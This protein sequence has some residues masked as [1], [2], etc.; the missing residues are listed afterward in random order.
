M[1]WYNE[2]W[3]K[4]VKVTIDHTKV[5]ATLYDFP[6]YIDLSELPADFH[7]NC[8]QTDARDIRVT[9][10]DGTTEVPREVVFYDSATDTGELHFKAPSLSSSVDADFYIYYG[11]ASATEPASNATYG[12]ENVWDSN[13]KAVYHLQEDP[14]GTAPQLLDSTSNNNDL[15]S[16][17][18]MTSGDSVAVKI[19]NGI[20]FDGSNDEL[21]SANNVGITGAGNRT[22]S[23]WVKQPTAAN[24]N[25]LGFGTTT[26]GGCFDM[27]FH[28]NKVAVHCYGGGYDNISY[29]PAYTANTLVHAYA[30][31]NGTAVN[32]FV[33]GTGG[34]ATNM[35][36]NTANSVLRIGKGTYATLDRLTGQ[37]D[38]VRVSDVVR[39][40]DWMGA[41][42]NNQSAP[43]TFSTIGTAE[44][45][46]TSGDWYNSSWDY[47]VKIT[48]QASQVDSTL[49]NFPVYVDLSGLPAGFHTNVN[50]TDARDIRVTTSDEVTEVPRE[51][52]FYDS[53]TDTGE[54][55]F[56]A[57]SLSSSADTDFYI[58]YGNSSATEPAADATYGRNNVWA[59]VYKSVLH[60]NESSGNPIESSGKVSAT[61]SGSLPD[62]QAGQIGNGQDFDGDGD[63]VELAND[64]DL[65]CTNQ[66]LSF[67]LRADSFSTHK[68]FYVRRTSNTDGEML[69]YYTAT[70]SINWDT[71]GSGKRWNTSYNPPTDGTKVLLHMTFDGSVKRLYVDGGLYASTGSDAHSLLNANSVARVGSDTQRSQYH[72]DGLFDEFRLSGNNLSADWIRAEYVNQATP[73]T[74]YTVGTQEEPPASGTSADSE[75]GLYI[76]GK[77]STNSTRGLYITGSHTLSTDYFNVE[78]GLAEAGDSEIGLYIW[79]GVDASSDLNLYIEGYADSSEDVNLYISGS[80]TSNSAVGLYIEGYNTSNEDVSLY[81]DA[82]SNSGNDVLLYVEGIDVSSEELGL[83]IS[84]TAD[85]TSEIGLYIQGSLTAYTDFGLYI[86]GKYGGNGEAKLYISGIDTGYSDLNIYIQGSTQ[87]S[88]ESNL[89]IEGRAIYGDIGLYIE[90]KIVV[91]LGLYIEGEGGGSGELGLYMSGI[92][93][94]NKE[95]GLYVQGR[96]I[97]SSEVG[98]YLEG[99]ANEQVES[100]L[101]IWGTDSSY[102]EFGLYA[103]GKDIGVESVGLYIH[104]SKDTQAEF[105]LYIEGRA[106]FEDIGLYIQGSQSDMADMELYVWGKDYGSSEASLYIWG[107]NTDS[108]DIGLYVEGKDV[109]VASVSLYIAGKIT[110]QIERGL[111]IGGIAETYVEFGLY[112]QGSLTAYADF[113]LY[114]IGIEC[115]PFEDNRTDWNSEDLDSQ[116]KDDDSTNWS[117]ESD[118]EKWYNS[119]RKQYEVDS[120]K[121]EC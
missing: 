44:E 121:P 11:N 65:D 1:A 93:S 8:N 76:Q 119:D 14:S 59:G 4:R 115:P 120:K 18:S 48:V 70:S 72:F 6:V 3:T 101:Y 112:I 46:P 27:L 12:S 110:A 81:I 91:D 13:F 108:S 100:G 64:S 98:L 16:A 99:C 24:K 52:V 68:A 96:V 114:I 2:S 31:Y 90:G 25:F 80:A 32:T 47:R 20:D 77:S 69:F 39:S 113:G 107:T 56:K 104:G 83:Y 35:T 30:T 38:E 97:D 36:L 17:G 21:V 29:A 50:Q 63:Y 60:L 9:T 41:E 23:A 106:I 67:W 5:S 19:G 15:T 87:G 82:Y 45:P 94:T 88:G 103:Y 49:S 92:E 26:T 105:G 10:S 51:V 95:I 57:P 109:V 55:H 117:A 89:Y 42:Y 53:T 62:A 61:F 40:A 74:F 37:M 111:Y 54:L 28:S 33:N 7:A 75:R 85:S 22:V 73:T 84:G 43:D 58:Y 116:W 71:A 86:G 102:S 118:I 34:T 79:G 78:F 66:S